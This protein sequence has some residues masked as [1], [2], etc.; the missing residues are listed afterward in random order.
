MVFS[1]MLSIVMFLREGMLPLVNS[2]IAVLGEGRWA[3]SVVFLLDFGTI[4]KN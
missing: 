3:C 4:G 1:V 2:M